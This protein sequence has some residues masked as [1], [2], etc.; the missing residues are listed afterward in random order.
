MEGGGQRAVRRASGEV[1]IS[2]TV[3]MTTT[4][5]P[6]LP[7]LSH[8]AAVSRVGA[9][10]Q[11]ITAGLPIAPTPKALFLRTTKRDGGAKR[12]HCGLVGKAISPPQPASRPDIRACLK[13]RRRR[14][15]FQ[16]PFI[17][18]IINL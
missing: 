11:A 5:T 8:F 18:C 13:G 2:V 3:G 15:A 12:R 4:P 7:S 17:V 6:S 10:S 9:A 16:Q 1:A 14:P